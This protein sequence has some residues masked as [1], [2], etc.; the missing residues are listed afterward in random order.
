MT[1]TRAVRILRGRCSRR[2]RA[3]DPRRSCAWAI[4]ACCASAEAGRRVRHAGAA[5]R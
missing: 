5:T 1:V 4:R 2:E 3:H